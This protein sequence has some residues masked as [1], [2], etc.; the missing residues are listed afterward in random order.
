MLAFRYM[1]CA[2]ENDHSEWGRTSEGGILLKDPKFPNDPAKNI[3]DDATLV[4][5][6]LIDSDVGQIS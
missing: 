6:E 4:Y 5:F 2:S 3:T 1:G